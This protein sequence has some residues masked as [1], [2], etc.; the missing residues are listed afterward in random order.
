[1][2]DLLRRGSFQASVTSSRDQT[3]K[4]LLSEWVHR[5]LVDMIL[6]GEIAPGTRLDEQQLAAMF[7]VSRFE[8]AREQPLL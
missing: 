4:Q 1:M 3:A 8:I 6:K 5:E 7:A 2:V